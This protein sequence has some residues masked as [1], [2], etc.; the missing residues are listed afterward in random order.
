MALF[1]CENCNYTFSYRAKPDACPD[2][3]K[4][5]AARVVS[6][7]TYT[8]K[9]TVP[10]IRPATDMESIWFKRVQEELAREEQP[11]RVAL[12]PA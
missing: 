6:N 8:T 2:C 10:A 11:R 3:G 9:T 5:V 1:T 12:Q 7:G 4:T